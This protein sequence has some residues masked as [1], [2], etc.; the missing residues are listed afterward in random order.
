VAAQPEA[1]GAGAGWFDCNQ[2]GYLDLCFMT[3]QG[4][5]T[6]LLYNPGIQ[7]FV[8]HSATAF[9]V[10]LQSASPGV[11]VA[12][13]D[14]N[15]DG[16]PDLFLTFNGANHLLLNHGD[17]VFEPISRKAGIGPTSE[18]DV[19]TASAAFLDYDADGLMDLYIANYDGS[20]NQFFH[21]LGIDEAGIP[22][23]T[24]V[25]PALGMDTAKN[26]QSDWGLG[27]AVSDYDNDGDPDIYL[28]N[29]YDGVGDGVL[30]PGGN[31][32]Y[33]NEGDGTFT[34]V[35]DFAGV[36][37]DGWAM[38]TAFGDF[39]NDGWMDLF[40]TN[41]WND[42][43]YQNNKNGT[44]TNVTALVGMPSAKPAE[45]E[46][47]P[48]RVCNGWGTQFIDF[49]ND[50]DL[51]IHVTNGYITNGEGQIYNE[52]NELWENR[53]RGQNG[54]HEFVEVGAAAGIN[55][56]GDGRGSAYA[57]FNQDG[58]IDFMVI[59][60]NYVSTGGNPGGPVP[61]ARQLLYVNQKNGTF[62][63]LGLKYKIRTEFLETD[64]KPSRGDFA[65]N[66][67]IQIWPHGTG[68]VTPYGARVTVKSG[69]LTQIREVAAG[70]YISTSSPYLH[71]GLRERTTIDEVTV[72][73]PS[74]TTVVKTN[75]AVD[76]ILNVFETDPTPIKLLS[77]AV[78]SAPG[79]ARLVWEYIDD[80]TMSAFALSR[81]TDGV[82]ALL[83]GAIIPRD[84]RGE[85]LD[86]GVP[87]GILVTYALDAFYRDG[88]R[89]R[90]GTRSFR[91]EPV[92][93]RVLGQNF[94]NPFTASTRIPLAS[95]PGATSIQVF[96]AAGRLVRQLRASPAEGS[97]FLDWDGRDGAGR[98]V[99][100]GT[101]F[102]RMP[103]AEAT[104]KM[105]R[106]P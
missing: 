2:D 95:V 29:D 37:D 97:Q 30:N 24:D 17:T 85:F 80:G 81:I 60:N 86:T 46:T 41:F 18:G 28:A 68:G 92:A 32:L 103:G 8:D 67:W 56:P 25:A 38:G 73:F 89:E 31:I 15:N 39:N 61:V 64:A 63:D 9:P 6:L 94:P 48:C 62:R 20:A 88:S 87:E 69:D 1:M 34:D 105:I 104:L 76:Q 82:E 74:G 33:R 13:A 43:L 71:F 5:I 98:P 91:F 52:P 7:E 70:S 3:P 23:F 53:G 78:E 44:F 42:A 19:L 93:P 100:A 49:D 102:Y 99:P 106:R 90:V 40:V 77:F 96:D 59:N 57:D 50:G 14:V 58:F 75:V 4:K 26:G 72:R 35:T 27:V 84:G 10:G 21:N 54:F 22:H 51:D 16:W 79:G 65:G 55:D 45:Q 11:S 47:Q 101:Y 36:R 83:A 66:H 12:C